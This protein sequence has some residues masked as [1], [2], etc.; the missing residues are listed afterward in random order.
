MSSPTRVLPLPKYDQGIIFG[1]DSAPLQ[2]VFETS[3]TQKHR[4]GA[5]YCDGD[6]IFRYAKAGAAGGCLKASM[7]QSQVIDTK[8]QEIVQTGHAWAVGDQYGTMLITTGGTWANNEFTDGYFFANKV[9]AVG[10]TY[11]VLASKIDS[12]DTIMHLEL[13]TPIRTAISVTTEC[14]LIPNRWYDVVIFPT[15]KTGFATGVPLVDVTNGYYFWAQTGGPA[16]L[17]TASDGTSTI[18]DSC[19]FSGTNAGQITTRTTLE[20]SFGNILL[21][22]AQSEPSIVNLTIDQ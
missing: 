9:A 18:G 7:T 1:P 6:R 2:S 22:G 16:P 19:G 21:V 14:S 13:E 5:R 17:I 10:D 11:R 15:T 12:T 3:A 8:T 4:L 20:A